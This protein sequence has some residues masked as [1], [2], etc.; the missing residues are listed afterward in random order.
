MASVNATSVIFTPRALRHVVCF[1]SN[2]NVLMK[3]YVRAN[4][5]HALRIN[6]WQKSAQGWVELLKLATLVCVA[7]STTMCL[8]TLSCACSSGARCE[9]IEALLLKAEKLVHLGTIPSVRQIARVH[10]VHDAMQQLFELRTQLKICE[11]DERLSLAFG[12]NEL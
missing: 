2:Y 12:C 5:P 4:F 10:L 1:E 9:A 7:S 3:H 6:C 8:S 11:H